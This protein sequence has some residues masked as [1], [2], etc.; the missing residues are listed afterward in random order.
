MT[1]RSF[2]GRLSGEVF[3]NSLDDALT[4]DLDSIGPHLVAGSLVVC[5]ESEARRRA[6]L[7]PVS[8]V[9]TGVLLV[10]AVSWALR[11]KGSRG[12]GSTPTVPRAAVSRPSRRRA[13]AAGHRGLQ[14]AARRAARGSAHYGRVAIAGAG[15]PRPAARS[16]L[17]VAPSRAVYVP[18]PAPVSV[19]TPHGEEFGFE[20]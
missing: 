5:I 10:L 6:W 15:A 7:R 9:V 20:R 8:V 13:S 11:F 16:T 2:D 12:H 14:L 3:E 17:P 19:A 1:V 18:A 4:E